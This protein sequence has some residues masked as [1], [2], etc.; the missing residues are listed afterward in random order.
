MGLVIGDPI[1]LNLE[2]KKTNLWITQ[3]AGSSQQ[4]HRVH[5][6]CCSLLL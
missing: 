4:Q 1:T 6:P 5:K 2:H 3:A